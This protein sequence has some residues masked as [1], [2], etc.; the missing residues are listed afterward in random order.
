MIGVIANALAVL[1]LGFAGSKIGDKISKSLQDTILAFIPIAIMMIGVNAGLKGS[2]LI[3]IVSLVIG[4]VIGEKLDLEGSVNKLGEKFKKLLI[5]NPED[6]DSKFVEGYVTAT[7]IFC[8]GS[9]GILG[10]LD[11]GIRGNSD[12]LLAKASIDG[13]TA[14][15]LASTMGIGVAVSGFSL[16]I[17]QGTLTILASFL[18]PIFSEAVIAN[19][20]GIGG[21]MIFAIGLQMM[22]IKNFKI[23]NTLPALLVPLIYQL[24]LN[25][26]A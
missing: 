21:V 23:A 10:S 9:M 25:I 6:N 2:T 4:I 1:I 14:L 16:L 18:A 22:K 17:Y 20:S 12:I 24:I 3:I 13:I 15:I 5:K 7:L 8:M 26:I 19:I 11:A